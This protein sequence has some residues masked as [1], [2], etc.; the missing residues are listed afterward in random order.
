MNPIFRMTNVY[1]LTQV[2]AE[3]L[4]NDLPDN[5][6]TPNLLISNYLTTAIFKKIPHQGAHCTKVRRIFFPGG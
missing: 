4:A 3:L 1:L 5:R 2:I 6:E